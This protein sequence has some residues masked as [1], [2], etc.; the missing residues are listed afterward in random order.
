[1]KRYV[2]VTNEAAMEKKGPH[3]RIKYENGVKLFST[4]SRSAK[5]RNEEPNHIHKICFESGLDGKGMIVA[6]KSLLRNFH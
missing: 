1:M 4:Q 6:Q 5:K 3:K 2:I